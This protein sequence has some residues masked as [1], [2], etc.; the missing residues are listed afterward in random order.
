M[1]FEGLE[2]VGPVSQ[3]TWVLSQLWKDSVRLSEDEGPLPW[4]SKT[5][6]SEALESQAK[7]HSSVI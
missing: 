1:R 6:T 5:E 4:A 7:E 3:T 2:G